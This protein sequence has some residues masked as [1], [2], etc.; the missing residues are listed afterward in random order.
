MASIYQFVRDTLNNGLFIDLFRQF[1]LQVTNI[2]SAFI[3]LIQADDS[4][5][6]ARITLKFHI[7]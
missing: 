5:K 2:T 1:N 4:L 6:V 3:S 7:H